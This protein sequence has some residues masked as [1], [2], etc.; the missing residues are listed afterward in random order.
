M[1]F[2][3]WKKGPSASFSAQGETLAVSQPRAMQ[4]ARLW[5]LWLMMLAAPIVLVVAFLQDYP[6]LSLPVLTSC[7]FLPVAPYLIIRYVFFD[8]QR[9]I[10]SRQGLIY[11]NTYTGKEEAAP[12]SA[13]LAIRQARE[14]TE[15]KILILMNDGDTLE[16]SSNEYVNLNQLW[17]A[18]MKV[19]GAKLQR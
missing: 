10:I 19:A 13:I 8:Y 12:L 2:D 11:Q 15:Q 16:L 5:G 17:E 3:I 4:Q 7:V 18:L 1:A 14:E 9:F 6:F